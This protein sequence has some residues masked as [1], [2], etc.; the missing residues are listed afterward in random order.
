MGAGNKEVKILSLPSNGLSKRNLKCHAKKK[1]V[2][3]LAQLPK[4]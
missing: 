1:P 2:G 4:E 3:V